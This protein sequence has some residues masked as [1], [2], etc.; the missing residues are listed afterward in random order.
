M[1]NDC[2][3]MKYKGK[4]GKKQTCK[5]SIHKTDHKRRMKIHLQKNESSGDVYR[6]VEVIETI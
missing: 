6:L 2:N 1:D 5:N 3:R 4:N